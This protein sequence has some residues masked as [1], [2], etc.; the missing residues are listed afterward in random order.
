VP[1]IFGLYPY[2]S[3][4]IGPIRF[5]FGG[6][7]G[8]P[9]NNISSPSFEYLLKLMA[10]EEAFTMA[11]VDIPGGSKIRAENLA[12]TAVDLAFA[13]LQA[14][15]PLWMFDGISR[16]YARRHPVKKITVIQANGSFSTSSSNLHPSLSVGPSLLEDLLAQGA[17]L[18]T[19]SGKRIEK[20]LNGEKDLPL[21]ETAWC[22]SAYWFHQALAE[23]MDALA[24]TKLVASYEILFRATSSSKINT[25]SPK[26][27]KTFFNLKMDQ[28]LFQNPS[29]KAQAFVDDVIENRSRVLHGDWSTL[30]MGH[31]DNR[32]HATLFMKVLLVEYSL[33]LDDYYSET[34]KLDRI[35]AFLDW[36]D[37]RRNPKDL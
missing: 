15:A 28:E 30:T 27:V 32:Q 3:F 23:P 17:K 26:I 31:R 10:A 34:G 2:A 13:A 1:C 8:L 22:D 14:F 7:Y 29:I 9:S 12:D 19:S 11:V 36:I 21:L 16:L 37:N 20:Y 33:A 4:S 35:D 5:E 6:T 24:V 25:L 18:V